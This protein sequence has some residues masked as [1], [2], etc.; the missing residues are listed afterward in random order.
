MAV[1]WHTLPGTI[2]DDGE[3]VWVRRWYYSTPFEAEWSLAAQLFTHSSGLTLAWD[4]VARWKHVV[5]P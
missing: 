4:R 2:P 3:T 5:E 1:V